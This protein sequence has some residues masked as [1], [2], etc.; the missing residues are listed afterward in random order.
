MPTHK[1]GRANRHKL[2]PEIV[3]QFRKAQLQGKQQA[4]GPPS[5][6][7][8]EESGLTPSPLSAV[9]ALRSLTINSPAAAHTSLDLHKIAAEDTSEVGADIADMAEK[10]VDSQMNTLADPPASGPPVPALEPAAAAARA[11]RRSYAS[12]SRR[13]LP[14]VEAPYNSPP[15]LV[16]PRLRSSRSASSQA[17]DDASNTARIAALEKEVTAPSDAAK[18][19]AL[20]KELAAV[21][22]EV[23]FIRTWM[24][25]LDRELKVVIARERALI[26]QRQK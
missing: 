9:S 19:A 6:E 18:I 17:S 26:E 11:T 20:E 24:Q 7:Q 8:A 12:G 5:E 1:T 3:L 2:T 14:G 22:D 15:L 23:C 13:R 4:R 16:P 25:D 21:K 10:Y